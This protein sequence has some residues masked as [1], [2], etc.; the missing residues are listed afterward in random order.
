MIEIR[1]KDGAVLH[2]ADADT[3]RRANLRG[4]N[5]YGANLRG[6]NLYGA[7]LYGA[8]LREADLRGANLYGA[9]LYGANL[10]WANLRGANLYGANLYGA[11]LRGADLRGADLRCKQYVCK[12]H[13][14]RNVI[15]AIDDDVRIGCE[16][17]PLAEWLQTFEAV[18]R[19]NKYTEAEI[20]EYGG[21]LRQIA[22]VVAA[23]RGEVA[24]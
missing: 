19:E 2:T 9:N 3:L 1:D 18:G 22:A 20:A 16:R 14:S 11:D 17:K 6:A 24:G 10:Y 15:V 13:A 7:N 4:A 21:W 5:L 8:N 23:R 12:I